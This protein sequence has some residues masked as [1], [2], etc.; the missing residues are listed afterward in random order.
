[1]K[2]FGAIMGTA[3]LGV[4]A[5]AFVGCGK[6]IT[7]KVTLTG[8]QQIPVVA[9]DGSSIELSAGEATVEFKRSLKTRLVITQGQ[10]TAEVKL[11]KSTFLNG[12][13]EFYLPSGKTGQKLD[14]DAKTDLRAIRRYEKQGSAE[15]FA[16]GFCQT[17]C[18][19]NPSAPECIPPQFP[20]NDG[21]WGNYPQWPEHGDRGYGTGVGYH[22]NCPGVMPVVKTYQESQE[23]LLIGF[24]DPQTPGKPLIGIF[25]GE[26][27]LVTQIVDQRATGPCTLF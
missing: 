3:V 1:M 27:G 22:P 4:S 19:Q 24:R 5:L 11:P 15:C 7:G 13:R 2:N 18:H 16:A 26:R 10:K 23:I 21:P 25:E 17:P 14:L 12:T 20:R 6:P 8:Q 9:A